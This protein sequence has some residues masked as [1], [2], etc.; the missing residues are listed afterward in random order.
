LLSSGVSSTG[1]VTF[2]DVFWKQLIFIVAGWVIYWSTTKLNI[3]I[4]K[5]PQTQIV[6]Y[7]LTI[8]LLV[9]T[10]IWGL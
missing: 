2:T 1:S 8:L 3:A 10:L 4:F 6:I 7:V 9:A 5:Y